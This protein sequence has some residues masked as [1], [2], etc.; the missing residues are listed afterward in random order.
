MSDSGAWLTW[1]DSREEAL[2][3][4]DEKR[5]KFAAKL[6]EKYPRLPR[7][8]KWEQKVDRACIVFSSVYLCMRARM[9]RT[10]T[11]EIRRVSDALYPPIENPIRAARKARPRQTVAD[12]KLAEKLA[13]ER[14]AEELAAQRVDGA[15]AGAP[16]FQATKSAA[17]GPKKASSSDPEKKKA[18]YKEA[19]AKYKG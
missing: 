1:S 15:S 10:D 18:A 19:M 3:A 16:K 11:R 13:E 9:T 2:L 4:D 12:L 5:A 6:G 17:E 7:D 14:L 8:D